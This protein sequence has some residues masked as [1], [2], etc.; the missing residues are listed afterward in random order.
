MPNAQLYVRDVTNN[1]NVPL[2]V[3]SSNQLSVNDSTAQSSLSSINTAL[4]GTLTVSNSISESSLSNIETT[5]SGTISV[6]DSTAALSLSSIESSL[7]GTLVV[8]DGTAQSSLANIESSLAGTI[9]TTAAISRDQGGFGTLNVIQGDVSNSVNG[10]NYR[11]VMVFGNLGTAGSIMIQV[12][13]NN[14]DW[15]DDH[16]SEFFS[17]ATS[18]DVGGRFQ[19]I[20]KH[21][22]VKFNVSG[23]VEIRWAMKD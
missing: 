21:W 3:D 5:L 16:S 14:T 19:S 1:K 13:Y 9:T 23:S 18:Y 20:A 4:G 6:S 8:S 15:Y 22:R 11:N 7:A 2:Q 12:S 10:E 17:N